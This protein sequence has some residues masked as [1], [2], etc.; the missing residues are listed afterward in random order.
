MHSKRFENENSAQ[1]QKI[2]ISAQDSLAKIISDGNVNKLSKNYMNTCGLDISY[3]S[4]EPFEQE[5]FR[6]KNM[7]NGLIEINSD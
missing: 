3:G 2:R 1:K 7:I 4:V 6:T 5:P